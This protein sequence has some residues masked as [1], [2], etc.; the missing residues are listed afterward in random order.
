MTDTKFLAN[1]SKKYFELIKNS[2][3][4]FSINNQKMKP[5][6][7]T[8]I[9]LHPNLK[10]NA[11]RYSLD[12]KSSGIKAHADY[13]NKGTITVIKTING[14]EFAEVDVGNEKVLF[15]ME[16]VQAIPVE[17][18][19]SLIG[20]KVTGIKKYKYPIFYLIADS[21]NFSWDSSSSLN[22]TGDSG[23][24]IGVINDNG[25]KMVALQSDSDHPFC[26]QNYAGENLAW[27][28]AKGLKLGG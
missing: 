25:D 26:V 23:T 21:N 5:V 13:W 16:D 14:Q 19:D 12:G 1:Q 2:D 27:F 28:N 9:G 7:M 24:V 15:K 18:S 3:G 17:V 8:Y 4:S 11:M 6:K 22:D 20:K 10:D